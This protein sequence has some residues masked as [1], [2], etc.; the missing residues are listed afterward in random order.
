MKTSEASVTLLERFMAAWNAH[1][2]D[3]LIACMTEEPVFIASAGGEDLFGAEYRGAAEVRRGYESLYETFADARWRDATHFATD[4][5]G[6][7]AWTFSGTHRAT[8]AS[9][10]VR[11][12]DLFQIEDGLIAVKDSYRKQP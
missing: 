4:E 1:D 6:F 9:V 8:G 11:G 3:A 5:Q 10:D 12:C 7:S 2:L